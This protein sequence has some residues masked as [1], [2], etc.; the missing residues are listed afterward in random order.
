MVSGLR[1][2]LEWLGPLQKCGFDPGTVQ[3]VKVSSVV[4]AATRIQFLAQGLPYA[5]GAAINRTK[6]RE[7]F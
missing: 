7:R 6:E 4:A 3:W 5:T 2:Q 1:I